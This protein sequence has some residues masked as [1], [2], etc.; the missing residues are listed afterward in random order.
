MVRRSWGCGSR[1]VSRGACG[2]GRR[3]GGGK[4]V[5]RRPRLPSGLACVCRRG[6]GGTPRPRPRPPPPPRAS[7]PPTSS[8][9][10]H[11]S[12]AVCTNCPSS[13]GSCGWRENTG[14][15]VVS[16]AGDQ[17][18]LVVQ[19]VSGHGMPS[20]RSSAKML[21]YLGRAGAAAGAGG[22]FAAALPACARA[23]PLLASAAARCRPAQ[24]AL[25]ARPPACRRGPAALPA[26]ALSRSR[27]VA[28]VAPVPLTRTKTPSCR[29]PP[30][31][32]P[33]SGTPLT[34]R[35]G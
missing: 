25:A 33:S 31:C 5:S 4:G 2:P 6:E 21:W 32:P 35:R 17:N 8:G 14:A 29:P 26:V 12:P 9:R 30:P 19:S 16:P 28:P 20:S 3:R 27:P 10:L 13:A 22:L 7:R 11:C 34:G 15:S 18:P 24:G 1:R 23:D